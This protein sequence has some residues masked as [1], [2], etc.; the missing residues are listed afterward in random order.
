MC[1]FLFFL[2]FKFEFCSVYIREPYEKD[3][4]WHIM[5]GKLCFVDYYFMAMLPLG[6][7][8]TFEKP[9]YIPLHG[10]TFV[11]KITCQISAKQLVTLLTLVG[12]FLFY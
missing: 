1:N 10:A 3:Q 2:L 11:K 6:Y 7:K 4:T 12:S 9:V 5:K 8:C